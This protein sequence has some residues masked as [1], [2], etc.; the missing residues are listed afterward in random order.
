MGKILIWKGESALPRFVIFFSNNALSISSS[1]IGISWLYAV[2]LQVLATMLSLAVFCFWPYFTFCLRLAGGVLG[3]FSLEGFCKLANGIL[4]CCM[5]VI[6][7][8]RVIE[9]IRIL[10][11]E[12]WSYPAL[13]NGKKRL[14]MSDS[15]RERTSRQVQL[16][17]AMDGS[18][19]WARKTS[20]NA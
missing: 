9:H 16:S 18:C 17:T 20:D 12:L 4:I 7:D 14:Q 11:H 6:K 5:F 15:M 1:F 19:R 13:S 2:A 3:E 10:R 8:Y